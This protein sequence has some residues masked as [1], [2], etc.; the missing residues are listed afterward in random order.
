MPLTIYHPDF[1]AQEKQTELRLGKAA[2]RVFEKSFVGD[3]ETVC[4]NNAV[5]T[6]VDTS[7]LATARKIEINHKERRVGLSD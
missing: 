6:T 7:V 1:V 2:N 4:T 5:Q 3:V